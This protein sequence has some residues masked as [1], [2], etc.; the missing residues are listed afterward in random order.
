V[1]PR[2]YYR[3]PVTEAF[4]PLATGGGGGGSVNEIT[5]SAT[6]PT[7][8]S[9]L[10]MDLTEARLKY[11]NPVTG[12]YIEVP[13]DTAVPP[14]DGNIRAG[15]GLTGG[16]VQSSSPTLN[17]GAGAGI[18]VGTDTVAVNK[19]T[20]DAWYAPVSGQTAVTVTNWNSAV[21][22]NTT[23]MA[24]NATNAP[25]NGWW[26]GICISGSSTHKH[27]LLWPFSLGRWNS[28]QM[29]ERELENGVWGDWS[30][31]G[32]YFYSR[33][34]LD[35][36]TFVQHNGSGPNQ[37]VRRCF[38]GMVKD[39]NTVAASNSDAWRVTYYNTAGTYL[40]Q[41]ISIPLGTG[42]VNMP[43]T[44]LMTAAAVRTRAPLNRDV[45]ATVGTVVD[46][47]NEMLAAAG[48]A[49][50]R[51]QAINLTEETTE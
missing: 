49:T 23:Y 34:L 43:Q 38:W 35:G 14:V 42:I 9:E 44:S 28:A 27:Q 17:V 39:K 22:N 19:G 41:A 45:A 13:V 7:D 20:L 47:V 4:I 11:R 32:A 18:T 31:V 48:V 10:W 29:W 8:G 16:G 24:N 25:D 30:R 51:T 26:F 46:I 36:G 6:A 15:N 33:D 12:V 50:P 37:G 2:L 40:G 21:N 1:S 5:V 3:D